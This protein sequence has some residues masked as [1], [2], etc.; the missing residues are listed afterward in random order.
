MTQIQH[1]KPRTARVSAVR[2]DG[3]AESAADIVTALREAGMTEAV[4]QPA[5]QFGSGYVYVTVDHGYR[6]N[7][8]AQMRAGEWAV[9]G[10]SDGET[11]VTLYHDDD[12]RSAF[13]AAP[14][15][16]DSDEMVNRGVRAATAKF[17]DGEYT[18]RAV[19]LAFREA[20]LAGWTERGEQS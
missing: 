13:E 18:A 2:W 3:S 20:Y 4:Y 11:V 1:F 7:G 14:A 15:A 17:P 19:A 16:V 10:Y 8:G 5:S 9:I 12:F 6:G